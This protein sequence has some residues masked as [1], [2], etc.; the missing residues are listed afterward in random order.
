M[1]DVSLLLII[2]CIM[3]GSA[4]FM[5][6]VQQEF[7]GTSTS[8]TTNDLDDEFS[9]DTT[10]TDINDLGVLE[11][12]GRMFFWVFGQGLPLFIDAFFLVLKLAFWVLVYR[13]VRSGGG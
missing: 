2:F 7:T 8:Y 12:I 10:V 13:Q 9:T 3:L 5:P 1:N 11:S 4:L 6:S